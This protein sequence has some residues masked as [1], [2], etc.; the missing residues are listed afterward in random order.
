MVVLSDN[1]SK[2]E[3]LESNS[4]SWALRFDAVTPHFSR[5]VTFRP[6]EESGRKT[7][8]KVEAGE[9]TGALVINVTG[10]VVWFVAGAL[11]GTEDA[12]AATKT[13]AGAWVMRVTRGGV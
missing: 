2:D 7:G 10:G 8:G 9:E 6:S 12:F 1:D 13:G 4:K 3:T 11:V 5:I